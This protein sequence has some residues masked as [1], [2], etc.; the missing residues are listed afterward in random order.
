MPAY[1]PAGADDLV[2]QAAVLSTVAEGSTIAPGTLAKA[3]AALEHDLAFYALTDEDVQ[4]LYARLL[5]EYGDSG[6]SPPTFED[7]ELTLTE[8]VRAAAQFLID[9][10]MG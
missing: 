5:D 3:R 2:L 4:A 8:D 9:V 7:L 1:A 10:L 6:E